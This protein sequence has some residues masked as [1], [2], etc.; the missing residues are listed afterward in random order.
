LRKD[1][2][3]HTRER[4]LGGRRH[5]ER[6]H[7]FATLDPQHGATEDPVG[8]CVDDGLEEAAGLLQFDGPGDAV[9]RHLEHPH[10]PALMARLRLAKPHA[11]KFR[12]SEDGVRDQATVDRRAAPVE[13]VG[14]EHPEVVVETWVNARSP[15]T[16]RTA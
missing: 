7:E 3:T 15:F 12:I 6:V 1:H 11:S 9:H 5:P 16:S 14:L 8:S 10:V 13:Q 2:V 4:D